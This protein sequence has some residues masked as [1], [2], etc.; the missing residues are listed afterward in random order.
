MISV[1]NNSPGLI[2]ARGR[3]FPFGFTHILNAS[4]TSIQLD[5]LLGAVKKEYRGRGVDIL[6][7]YSQLKT[8]FDAGFK[9][10]DSH[11]IMENNLSMRGEMERAGSV[12]Y[13]KFRLYQKT[14]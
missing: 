5:S 8:A 12:I 3:L 11:H 9:I 6:I 10:I 2:K 7:G 1:P 13:K 14:M 4:K